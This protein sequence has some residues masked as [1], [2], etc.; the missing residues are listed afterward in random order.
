MTDDRSE[1]M[2]REALRR[3][4]DDELPGEMAARVLEGYHPTREDIGAWQK[5]L[6]G[7]GWGAPMWPAEFGGTGWSIRRQ[8][9]FEEA[10]FLA[11]DARASARIASAVKARV[12]EAALAVDARGVQLHDGVGITEEFEIGHH[13]R[14]L[15][16]FEFTAGS[17]AHHLQRFA[18][19]GA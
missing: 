15:L 14:R 5:I 8:H 7:H 17:R 6:A 4:L 3:L 19:L 11:L 13:Y 9:A 18:E 10:C 16:A 2:D 12:G 1:V